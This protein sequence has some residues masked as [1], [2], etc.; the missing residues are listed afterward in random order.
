MTLATAV[1]SRGSHRSPPPHR[2]DRIDPRASVVRITVGSAGCTA[3]L[4]EGEPKTNCHFVLTAAHCW[5][6]SGQ[7]TKEGKCKLL[8]GRVFPME[9]VHLAWNPDVAVA[10]IR[11]GEPLPVARVRPSLAP[12][13]ARVWHAGYGVHLPGS[14]EEG[15]ILSHDDQRSEYSMKIDASSGDSGSGIFDA[16]GDVVAAVLWGTDGRVTLASDT[17]C[18]LRA[19]DAAKARVRLQFGEDFDAGWRPLPLVT[20]R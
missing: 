20:V 19:L 14:F 18:I 2:G 4:L 1:A 12:I 5:G 13:G 9:L 10:V 3:T 17:N 11:T 7:Q 6:H 15:V 8:D 16:N